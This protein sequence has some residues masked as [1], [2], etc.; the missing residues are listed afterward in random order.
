M[1]TAFLK[2][3]PN[4]SE[5]SIQ[6]NINAKRFYKSKEGYSTLFDMQISGLPLPFASGTTPVMTKPIF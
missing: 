3:F 6:R 4:E 5:H 2:F 1:K